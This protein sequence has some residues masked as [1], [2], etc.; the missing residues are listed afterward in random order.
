M[1]GHIFF[2][3]GLS[4]LIIHEMD[5]IRCK[6]WRIFPGLSMLNDSWGYKIFLF[7]HIPLFLLLFIGLSG[8]GTNEPLINGL[9]IFFMVHVG[10]H[11]LFLTHKR[12]EFK[13]W[14]SWTI[15]LGAGLF[16]LLDLIVKLQMDKSA[17]KPHFF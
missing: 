13:D 3:L 15:I 6:E 10:L 7:A 2:Y 1:A 12:N 4:L 5:A 8:P 16:G 9:D 17:P 14:I 11:I